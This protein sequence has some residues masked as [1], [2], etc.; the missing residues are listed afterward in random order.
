MSYILP[1][2]YLDLSRKLLAF[3]EGRE[4]E[5]YED[6]VH[7][8]WHVGIGHNLE[9]DQ[10]PE[11]IAIIGHFTDPSKV[12]LTDEQIDALFEE[13]VK[14]ALEDLGPVLSRIDIENMGEGR[15][16]AILSMFFQMGGSGVR[17][18]KVFLKAVRDCDWEAAAHEMVTGSQG[19]ESL[20]LKQ[21]RD[22]C[23]RASEAMRVGYFEMFEDAPVLPCETDPGE[24]TGLI[25]GELITRIRTVVDELERR[26][27]L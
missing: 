20:W 23:L 3:E 22:R 24:L 6:S 19:G 11:E 5:A 4:N 14:D 27:G 16:A 8:I 21:T 18:F 7:K 2:G 17:K 12:V 25:D 1:A 26:L 9:V 13:D 15:F 10:T